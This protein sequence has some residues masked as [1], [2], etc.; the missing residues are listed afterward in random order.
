MI[1]FKRELKVKF[2]NVLAI[3]LLFYALLTLTACGGGGGGGG[4][5]SGG[6]DNAL[7]DNPTDSDGG[8]T[9]DGNTEETPETT[10][11]TFAV[12][13]TAIDVRSSEDQQ[14]IPEALTDPRFAS[15][16]RFRPSRPVTRRWSASL[17][18]PVD[19]YQ[20]PDRLGPQRGRALA[21]DALGLAG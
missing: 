16:W 8:D 18:C 15:R 10:S 3:Y 1:Q 14:I 21:N 7:V 20:C 12:T 4:G 2:L 9:E 13:V 17:T 19:A 6:G 5:G 11:N